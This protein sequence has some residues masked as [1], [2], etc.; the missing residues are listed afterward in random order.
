MKLNELK[1]ENSPYVQLAFTELNQASDDKL[2]QLYNQLKDNPKVKQ[3]PHNDSRM[4]RK[5]NALT[6][7]VKALKESEAQTVVTLNNKPVNVQSIEVDGINPKDRPDFA[8]AYIS[9]AEFKDG[10]KLTDDQLSDLTD[11]YGELVNE[12]AHESFH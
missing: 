11:K 5:F 7:K 3:D 4:V 12:L 1:E 8:D 10:T 6:K 2:K 9:Q